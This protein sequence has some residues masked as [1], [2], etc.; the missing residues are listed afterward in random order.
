MVKIQNIKTNGG[1]GKVAKELKTSL[2]LKNAR[3]LFPD[4]KSGTV[5]LAPG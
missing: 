1:A 2:L 3:V 4:P 5:T